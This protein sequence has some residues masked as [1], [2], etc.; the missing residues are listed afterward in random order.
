MKI[1]ELNQMEIVKGGDASCVISVIALGITFA[2]LFALGPVTG[3]TSWLALATTAGGFIASGAGVGA[4]CK[5][6]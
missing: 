5:K 4:S 1:L 6:E 2:G 3:G